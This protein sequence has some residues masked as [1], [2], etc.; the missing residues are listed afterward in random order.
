M[1]TLVPLR[2]KQKMTVWPDRKEGFGTPE[3]DF[4]RYT[5]R[6]K[7]WGPLTTYPWWHYKERE[8]G[9]EVGA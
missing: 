5:D 6:R 3:Q 8:L 9:G 4:C 2:Y 7:I 1:G